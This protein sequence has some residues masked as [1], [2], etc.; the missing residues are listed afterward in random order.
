MPETEASLGRAQLPAHV[1]SFQ[2]I[3][4]EGK[5]R[6]PACPWVEKDRAGDLRRQAAEGS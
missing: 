6:D 4:H 3:K 5:L 1:K 2:A